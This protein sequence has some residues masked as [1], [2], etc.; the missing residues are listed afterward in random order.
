MVKRFKSDIFLIIL[1]I[2]SSLLAQSK[3]GHWQFE[4]SG[5][6]S[7]DWDLAKNNGILIGSASYGQEVPLQEGSAYLWLDSALTN[8]YFKI[9]DNDDLDFTDENI[10]LSAWIYPVDLSTTHFFINKGVN[11]TVPKTTN[12]ALRIN[13]SHLEF[14]IRDANDKAQKVTSSFKVPLNQWTFV[15][16][17]YDFQAQ[18]VYMWNDPSTDAVDTLDFNKSFFS[19]DD[20]LVIGAWYVDGGGIDSSG[21]HFKGRI[22]D[23]RISGRL[24]DIF[25]QSTTALKYSSENRL[26]S[27]ELKQ[28][29]P[30]PFNAQTYIRFELLKSEHVLLNIYNVLGIRVSNLIDK[31][32][33]AGNY[34]FLYNTENLPS[35]VYY[36]RLKSGTFEKTNKMLLVK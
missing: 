36:Y 29:Y 9:E 18:K 17:Y 20:P 25:P 35:G 23:V 26:A 27:F 3:G 10:G 14:L 13:V 2:S 5:A 30:N 11:N 12:Y 31:R 33:E 16:I 8:N 19:N 1:L 34:K 21:F 4:T 22:D 24:D 6:D 32:L 15:A 28:N 7:A